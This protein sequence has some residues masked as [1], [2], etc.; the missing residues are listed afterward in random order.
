VGVTPDVASRAHKIQRAHVHV[1][2]ARLAKRS[3]TM[4]CI[5]T[6]QVTLRGALPDTSAIHN[7][8]LHLGP[9]SHTAA[10]KLEPSRTAPPERP[11]ACCSQR[12]LAE[13]APR[14]LLPVHS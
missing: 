14:S 3:M 11:E 6:M 7:D 1:S 9:A 2:P 13:A 12:V 10:A 4:A 5:R 8:G